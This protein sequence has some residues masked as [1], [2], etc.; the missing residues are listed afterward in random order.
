MESVTFVGYNRMGNKV[1]SIGFS[2]HAWVLA[3]MAHMQGYELIGYTEINPV[4]GLKDLG[5]STSWMQIPYLGNEM[6]N[7]YRVDNSSAYLLSVGDNG[8]R[9]RIFEKLQS[10]KVEFLRLIADSAVVKPSA[11]IGEA[12]V[13]MENA[14]IQTLAIVGAAVVINTGAVVEHECV[15]GD[16]AHLAPG[17]VLAGNVSVGKGSFIGA[18]SVIKQGVKIGDG[19]IVGAGSVVL[20]DVGDGEIVVGNPARIL[21]S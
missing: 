11:Q 9:R 15:V 5:N 10:Q 20:K 6:A 18:N 13:V 21:N 2:G 7:D 16:F 4:E 12:T 8:I 17:A 3:E 19:V 14:V 1:I